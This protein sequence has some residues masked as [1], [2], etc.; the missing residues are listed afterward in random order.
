MRLRA[1]VASILAVSTVSVLAPWA[2]LSALAEP[3]RSSTIVL[4]MVW[5][6]VSFNP[7]RG[8]DSGSY[9]ASSLI[10]EG[11]VKFDSNLKVAPALAESYTIDPDGL[12]YSFVLRPGLKFSNGQSL[13]AEDVKASLLMGASQYSPFRNDYKDIQSVDVI[14]AGHLNV[15]LSKTCQPLLSRLA[16][17]RVVP[18]EILKASD[19]GNSLL[20]RHPVSNGPFR[21]VR[22]QAGQELVFE[23]NPYY[24][25]APGQGMAQKIIWRVIPDKMA[26]AAALGRGEVDI[27]PVD[28]R[29]WQ[30]YLSR[31][32]AINARLVV[33]EFNGGR[34]I[35]L[36]F[37]LERSPWNDQPV[38]Q[39]LAHAINREAIKRTLYGGYGVVPDTDVP[40]T[41]WA[42]IKDTQKTTYAPQL[43]PGL[44]TSVGFERR[45]K[46][47][48]RDG[49]PLGLRILTIKD[50]EEVALVVA[51]DLE[52]AGIMAEVEV[53]EYSTLRRAYMQKGKFDLV[54]WSR[55]FGPDPECSMVWGSSGPLNFCRLK[56]AQV[57]KLLADGRTAPTQELRQAC[58]ASLQR[59]LARQLPWVFIVQPAV[60]VAHK[61]EIVNIQ[62]G[63]QKSAGLPWDNIAT[64]AAVW[65]RQ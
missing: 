52:R 56:D 64:N 31:D 39:A 16:E 9:C 29:I 23:R 33:E 60:V 43:V 24:Y 51:D 32:R 6:P 1:L 61:K 53:I 10:Y 7:I 2:C 19:H 12:T 22:W 37:N 4:G 18:A 49:K 14:D 47:Y 65:Q 20:A 15:H 34:T 27:A 41:S 28:G 11:L 3:E 57:D 58:Y 35:Y 54:L 62:K 59:Y 63:R 38:R 42:H 50:L 45:G 13:T 17:L 40:L 5:E 26:L 25:K 30:N 8:I 44:L 36:G 21:L 46:R 48:Y 55:S